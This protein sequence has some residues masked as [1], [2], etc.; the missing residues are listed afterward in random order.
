MSRK[1]EGAALRFG[2]SLALAQAKEWFAGEARQLRAE[3]ASD[4]EELRRELILA[5]A[6]LAQAQ[7]EAAQL[8]S[9]LRITPASTSTRLQ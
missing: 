9:L 2:H 1:S 5:R 3:I 7:Y 6:Q 8:R 4:V